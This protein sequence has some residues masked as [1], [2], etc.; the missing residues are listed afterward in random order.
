LRRRKG[1][2]SV[3]HAKDEWG[4]LFCP[5]RTAGVRS[6]PQETQ[7]TRPPGR[8]AGRPPRSPKRPRLED[9][10]LT[11]P[12]LVHEIVDRAVLSLKRCGSPFLFDR[13][14][15]RAHRGRGLGLA[16]QVLRYALF[17][18]GMLAMTG[19][20][21]RAF[22]RSREGLEAPDQNSAVAREWLFLPHSGDCLA[23]AHTA[24][25]GKAALDWHGRSHSTIGAERGRGIRWGR[26]WRA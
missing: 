10:S 26:H 25:G 5:G 23:P 7:G 24:Q 19:A 16:H 14:K 20:P 21:I 2:D 17:R 13:V 4:R 15:K 22:V 1:A 8:A 6:Q 18:Q 3:S 12:S 9:R 11:D